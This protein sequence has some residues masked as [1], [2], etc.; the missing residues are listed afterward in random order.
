MLRAVVEY[1]GELVESGGR[2]WNQFWFTPR[3]AIPLIWLRQ[4]VGLFALVWLASFSTNL[5][6]MF[7]ETG[8][9][10]RQVVHEATTGGMLDEPA[11]GFSYLFLIHSRTLLW[12]AHI[13]SLCV[14]GLMVFGVALRITTPLSLFVVLSYV[15]RAPMVTTAFETVMCT[16]LLYVCLGPSDSILSLNR[17]GPDRAVSWLANLAIR[18]IQAHLCGFYLLI[19]TSKL[20]TAVWRGGDA[21][22]Y[23]ATD[24]QHRLLDLSGLTS[25]TYL[26]NAIT[27][28]WLLFE[29]LFPVLIWIGKFRPLL[30]AASTFIWIWTAMAT[31]QVGYSLLM[32]CANAAFLQLN[33]LNPP[34]DS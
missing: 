9:I 16:L 29:L 33:W 10:S 2:S 3:S 23:L 11:T 20:G 6:G 26:M 27:H 7:G 21:T 24:V 17:R 19:A 13:L 4:L 1:W 12:I 5:E 14:L 15:H 8:W 28:S 32:I 34:A 30:V 18:L 25:S 31:G 22:W